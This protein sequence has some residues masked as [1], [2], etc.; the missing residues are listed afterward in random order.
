VCQKDYFRF[1][2]TYFI[3][4]CFKQIFV[5]SPLRQRDYSAET[6]RHYVKEINAH[7]T[8]SALAWCQHEICTSLPQR[9]ARYEPQHIH[10]AAVEC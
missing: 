6:C 10:Y 4:L 5:S 7:F 9:I 1:I 3:A 8:D 2:V